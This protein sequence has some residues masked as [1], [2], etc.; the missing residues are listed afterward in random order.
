M[1]ALRHLLEST[2]TKVLIG[3]LPP[4]DGLGTAL[5]ETIK[6]LLDQLP[7]LTLLPPPRYRD[8]YP[9]TKDMEGSGSSRLPPIRTFSSHKGPDPKY[10]YLILHSS[11]STKFPKPI[12]ITH[13]SIQTWWSGLWRGHWDVCGTYWA[14]MGVPTFHAMGIMI[15]VSAPISSMV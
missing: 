11:G 15:N 5:E 13:R 3:S 4:M 14:T 12:H 10:P 1:P 7:T 6:E 8:L 2:G 9:Q